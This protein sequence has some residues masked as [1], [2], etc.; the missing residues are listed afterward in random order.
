MANHSDPESCVPHREVCGEALAGETGRPAIEPRN[1]SKSGMPTELQFSEGNTGHGDNRKS[2]TDPTRSETLRMSGSD[3]HGS[4]EI[5]AAPALL[6]GG[7]GKVEDRN[8]VIHVVEKSDTPIVPRKPSNKGESAEAVEGRGVAEGN[9]GETPAGRTQSR[10]PASKGLEGIRE[11]A[12]KDGTHPYPE[13]RFHVKHPR[14][15]PC[16]V[17]PL[18]GIC[19]GDR[20]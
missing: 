4:W 10:E 15:E 14:Q 13:E 8:P 16:A 20:G 1:E 7:T 5:S 11:A 9:A 6:A 2:C 3:L 18:A 19:A 12:R 17:I